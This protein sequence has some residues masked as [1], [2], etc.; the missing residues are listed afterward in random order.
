MITTSQAKRFALLFKGKTN[1]YVKNLLPKEKPAKGEKIKTTI[2]NE[3][4]KVDDN[5]LM[6]HLSGEF[7][8]GICP[9]T[10][11]GKCLF[12]VLDIDYYKGKIRKML[13][14]IRDYQLPLVPFRS[15]SG[16]LHCYLF[17]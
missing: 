1:T 11:D 9:V 4:G 6:S 13:D 10:T 3:K 12:V 8:V 7:G 15:K 2:T 17:L 16:G 5:L 14:I